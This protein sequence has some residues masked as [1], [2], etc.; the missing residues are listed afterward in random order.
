MTLEWHTVLTVSIPLRLTG[1][2][3]SSNYYRGRYILPDTDVCPVPRPVDTNGVG[4]LPGKYKCRHAPREE[5]G[6]DEGVVSVCSD[7][8]H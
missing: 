2:G 5:V 1:V 8:D 7:V 4:D 3:G 6:L